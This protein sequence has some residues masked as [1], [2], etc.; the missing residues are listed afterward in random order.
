[1]TDTFKPYEPEDPAGYEYD[2]YSYEESRGGR[3]LWGRVALLGFGLLLAFFLGRWTAGGGADE[4]ELGELRAELSA[5]EA[6]NEQLQEELTAAQAAAEPVETPDTAATDDAADAA[7]EEAEPQTYTVQRGDTLRGIAQTFC[8]DPSRDDL[9]AAENGIADA[10]QLSVGEEL[11]L[12]AD[13]T[14]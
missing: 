5:A 4:G 10:T 3:V 13:C 6:E 2:E 1:M 14:G 11:I 9:I 7:E 8:G 12:P